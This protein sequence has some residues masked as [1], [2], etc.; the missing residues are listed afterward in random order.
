MMAFLESPVLDFALKV[1]ALSPTVMS[2]IQS[3]SQVAVM[4]LA[5]AFPERVKG[6]EYSPSAASIC[7]GFTL[8]V[9]EVS[10]LLLSLLS[11]QAKTKQAHAVRVMNLKITFF[12]SVCC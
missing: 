7:T 12:M 10:S 4:S 2:E 8:T 9:P 6:I 3:T 5:E 1:R 11:E